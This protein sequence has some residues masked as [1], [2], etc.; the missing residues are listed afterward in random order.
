MTRG[1]GWE[2]KRPKKFPCGDTALNFNFEGGRWG[3]SKLKFER[4]GGTNIKKICVYTY[5]EIT[6]ITL[7]SNESYLNK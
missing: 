3:R 1:V 4:E 2:A 7:I 5:T 6:P